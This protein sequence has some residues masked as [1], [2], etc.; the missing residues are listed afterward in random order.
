MLR[1]SGAVEAKAPTQERVPYKW[2]A[3][4]IVAISTLNGTLDAHVLNIALP[5]IAK[6]LH[7]DPSTV[8]WV[9]VIY[10]LVS[11]GLMLTFGQIGDL[12]GRKRIF[13][14]GFIVFTIG[15]GLNGLAQNVYQLIG[16]RAIQG[17]GQSMI[18][19]NG[20]A[21]VT[22]AFPSTERGKAL[23]ILSAVA[24]AGQGLG[25]VLGGLLVD[26]F[27]W[28]SIFYFRLPIGIIG[29]LAVMKMLRESERRKGTIHFDF[30]GAGTLFLGIA[31][32]LFA[33]TQGVKIGFG[34]SLVIVTGLTA[35][36][37]LAI[38]LWQERRTAQPVVDLKLFSNRTFASA[39]SSAVINFVALATYN[40]LTPF[41]LTLGL[42]LSASKAGLVM[43]SIPVTRMIV[44][45][46]SG[47]LSDKIGSRVLST[48]GMVILTAGFLTFSRLSTEGNL[49]LIVAVLV[50]VG[51][52]EGMFDSPNNSAIMGS[53][54]RENLGTASATTHTVRQLGLSTGVATAGAIFTARQAHHASILP[55]VSGQA[56]LQSMAVM[57]AFQDAILVASIYTAIGILTAFV[58]EKRHQ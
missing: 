11:S 55:G 12:V 16:F 17:I 4:M 42:G 36:V 58:R 46:I 35:L 15:I 10:L 38:F 50:L 2:V 1:P 29:T 33:L 6:N 9:S 43:I 25:P 7:T 26:A 3:L 45:P 27:D 41:Y 23:G 18:L 31:G 22:A 47:W 54:P 40:F 20:N 39:T 57:G 21:L 44:T 32:L 53:V 28:R 52:G 34:S 37:S 13:A 14:I 56:N 19:A 5:T 48:I 51:F 30:L 49:A 24:G 8:L